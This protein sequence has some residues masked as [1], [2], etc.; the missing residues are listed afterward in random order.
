ML[1]AIA[2]PEKKCIAGFRKQDFSAHFF[3]RTADLKKA[4]F[5]RFG[6]E[7]NIQTEYSTVHGIVVP[8]DVLPRNCFSTV[9]T[10]QETT[11]SPDSGHIG[12]QL[13]QFAA[14][15]QKTQSD[16]DRFR[17]FSFTGCAEDVPG[18]FHYFVSQFQIRGSDLLHDQ[19]NHRSR[20][21]TGEKSDACFFE[22][23]P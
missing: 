5:I 10:A 8:I 22:L 15:Q 2:D 16:H 13:K 11:G 6:A 17:E 1:P 12:R 9:E 21:K 7:A 18:R 19:I 20:K 3:V 14:V 4:A 23:C